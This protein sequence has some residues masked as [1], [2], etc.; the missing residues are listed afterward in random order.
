[1]KY[2]CPWCGKESDYT[3]GDSDSNIESMSMD[4]IECRCPRCGGTFDLEPRLRTEQVMVWG[5]RDHADDVWE[6]Y[7]DYR[8]LR[9]KYY[10]RENRPKFSLKPQG[11]Q[12]TPPGRAALP[13]GFSL[14][15]R[16]RK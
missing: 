13:S 6:E 7:Y 2:N 10:E 8:D 15:S 5:Y 12:L 3:C 1:M 14:F 4:Y 9:Q 16:R 11:F